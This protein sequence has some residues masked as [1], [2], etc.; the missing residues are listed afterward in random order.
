MNIVLKIWELLWTIIQI[1]ETGKA[2]KRA[3]KRPE[4][5]LAG[6]PRFKNRKLV[7]FSRKMLRILLIIICNSFFI[8]IC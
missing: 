4:A 6:N 1:S 3:I 8:I 5:F 2:F 7:L